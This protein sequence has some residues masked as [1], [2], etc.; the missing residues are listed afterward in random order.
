MRDGVPDAVLALITV[1]RLRIPSD[2][3]QRSE[4]MA[5]T[6]PKS[7]RSSFQG[8]GDQ[9]SKLMPKMGRRGEAGALA[10]MS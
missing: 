8:D 5:I 2:A 3:D 6:I 4:L 1:R 7:W 9:R 10:T